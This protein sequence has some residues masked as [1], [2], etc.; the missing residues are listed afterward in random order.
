MKRRIFGIGFLLSCFILAGVI[1]VFTRHESQQDDQQANNQTDSRSR[2]EQSQTPRPEEEP[3]YDLSSPS[4]LT[5]I[6]NKTRP[7]LPAD[8]VPEDLITPDVR[9]RLAPSAEQMRFRRVAHDQLKA[10]F[11]AAEAD[12]VQLVFGSGYRSYALQKQFY[13]SYVARDGR[14]TADRYSARP[15]T[16]EHQTGLSF[17]ATSPS[18]TC[19]L[20][21]CFEDTPQGE[22]L[23]GHAHEYGFIMRYLP[24]KEAITGYQYEPW[25]FRFIGKDLARKVHASDQTLE[26]YFKLTD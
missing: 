2:S 26:E 13:E 6:V 11:A 24:G 4:S 12:D 3:S 8:Y 10:M 7:P 23:D 9:L 17:D 18:Q 20:Q 15:G 14:E 1:F 22:W 16:S 25:H 19:H 21:I 5:V